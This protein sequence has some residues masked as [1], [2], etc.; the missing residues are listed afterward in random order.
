[1]KAHDTSEFSH[2]G[3]NIHWTGWK[4]E[5]G[6]GW[7]NDGDCYLCFKPIK[8][9]QFVFRSQGILGACHWKCKYPDNRLD[10]L[11]GQW[12]AYHPVNKTYAYYVCVG[13]PENA[14]GR[15]KRGECFDIGDKVI[16]TERTGVKVKNKLVDV[17]REKII[18]LLEESECIATK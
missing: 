16:V 15:F 8:T 7:S 9:K 3:W 11:V 2:M 12:V 4:G 1:M 6:L 10:R 14:K 13:G 17:G 5:K 18:Q